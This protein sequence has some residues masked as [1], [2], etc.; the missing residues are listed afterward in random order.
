LNSNYYCTE[1]QNKNW[2]TAIMPGGMPVKIIRGS[3]TGSIVEY[4]DELNKHEALKS[5]VYYPSIALLDD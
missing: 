1:A 5:G 3:M 2:A 4:S